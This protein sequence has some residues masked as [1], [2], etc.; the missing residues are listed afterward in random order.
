MACLA[1]CAACLVTVVCAQQPQAR[2]TE[3]QQPA[4]QPKQSA[5]PAKKANARPAGEA[6]ARE[7][8]D[9]ASVEQM[10]KQC[11]ALDTES[12]EIVVEMLAEVAP[13]SVRN[14]LNLAATGAFDTTTFSRVVKGF[15]IQGGNLATR[16]KL[17]PE[18]LRR[19]ART[20]P[21]EPNAVKH[22]RGILSMARTDEA[23][24]GTTHFFILAGDAAHL[25]GT[26]AAFGRV[27]RGM[28]TVDAINNGEL[29]GDKPK[30]PVRLRRAGVAP[31]PPQEK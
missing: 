10:S 23:N 22:V 8:F 17:T 20:V 27:R 3:P 9:T 13:E 30:K 15:I 18:L 29:E 1:L 31:C 16:E 25:D 2:Q 26:F 11:V 28:E 6:A 7:P 24:S 19:A 21:D 12:G 5:P 14:F 4:A